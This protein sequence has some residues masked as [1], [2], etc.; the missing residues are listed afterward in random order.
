MKSTF[1]I[2]SQLQKAIE[3]NEIVVVI[4]SFQQLLTAELF[5]YQ[6][7]LEQNKFHILEH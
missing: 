7:V 3:Q 1:H 5:L 6:P 4:F 2:Q